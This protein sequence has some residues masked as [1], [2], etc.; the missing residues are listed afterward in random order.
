MALPIKIDLPETFFCKEVRA[1][2]EVTEKT[3][4]I[5]AVHL[6]L[7]KVFS[8]L[9]NKYGIRFQVAYGTLIGAVRHKGFIPWDDDFDVW[10]DRDNYQKLMAIRQE[11]VPQ[12]YFL[13]TPLSDRKYFVGLS[14]FRNSLTTGAVKGICG[15]DYNSGIYID[16]YVLDGLD[17]TPIK[18]RTQWLC[19]MLVIKLIQLFYQKKPRSKRLQDLIFYCLKPL[20]M[21]FGYERLVFLYDSILSM[22]TRNTNKLSYLITGTKHGKGYWITKEEL[23]DTI[24]LP[25]ENTYVP[26]SRSYDD[27]LTRIYGNY[28]EFPSVE[29]RGK[30]HEGVLHFEPEIPYKEYFRKSDRILNN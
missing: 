12:P 5:W 14:R 21:L 22:R 9:C 30:W 19:K 2:Y 16:I 20:S 27:I 17:E 1:G 4:K 8:D 10:M 13:Q 23:K 18:W 3:K 7:F 24:M 11:D 28:M 6:D 25:Y 15:A 29:E 26:V